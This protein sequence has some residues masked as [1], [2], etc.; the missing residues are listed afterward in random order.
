MNLA[1]SMQQ[2]ASSNQEE[3]WGFHFI[4]ELKVFIIDI[5]TKS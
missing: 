3:G 4:K 1:T 5:S 2:L